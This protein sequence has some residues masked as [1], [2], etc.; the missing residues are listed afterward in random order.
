MP[1]PASGGQSSTGDSSLTGTSPNPR[2]TES[3]ET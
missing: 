1:P 3:E 2:Y